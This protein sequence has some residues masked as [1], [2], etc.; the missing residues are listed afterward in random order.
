MP[1]RP[2]VTATFKRKR[3]KTNRSI[4]GLIV[5]S[6]YINTFLQS[7]MTSP[8]FGARRMN[9]CVCVCMRARR[10]CTKSIE[11]INIS[12]RRKPCNASHVS[13]SSPSPNLPIPQTIH[14]NAEKYTYMRDVTTCSTSECELAALLVCRWSVFSH[15]FVCACR[16]IAE[17]DWSARCTISPNTV[18][19]ARTTTLQFG[20]SPRVDAVQFFASTRIVFPSLSFARTLQ[21]FT[22]W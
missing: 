21:L 15:V 17:F 1:E 6:A 4:H 16:S 7:S 2:K 22:F 12:Q 3:H 9:K 10:N 14:D 18:A 19:A 11:S 5:A 13:A 8:I 20:P